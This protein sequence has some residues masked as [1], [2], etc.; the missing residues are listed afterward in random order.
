MSNAAPKLQAMDGGAKSA[1]ELMS[2]PDFKA[3]VKKRW[4][5][6]FSLLTALFIT[7]YGYILVLGTNREWVSQKVSDGPDAVTTIAIPLGIAVI[8]F[9]WVLT[10][11]YV[12]WANRSYDPEVQRL[13]SQLK[14]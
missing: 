12:V 4:T 8:L 3:L 1:H 11:L 6:S 13:K 5:V 14:H 7:Y 9:A 2:S 10:A